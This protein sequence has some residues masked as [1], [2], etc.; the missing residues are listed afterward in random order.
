MR[1]FVKNGAAPN[2]APALASPADGITLSFFDYPA[3]TWQPITG[4]AAYT[5]QIATNPEGFGSTLYSS[6]TAATAH[7]PKAKLANGTYYWRVV[8]LDLKNREGTASAVRSFVSSYLAPPEIIEP[9]DGATPSFTPTF[10]WKALRGAEYYNIQYA[11]DSNFTEAVVTKM[12]R[13]TTYTP[14]DDLQNELSYYWH[15]RAAAGAATSDW[16][17]TRSFI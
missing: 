13:S 7:Q 4:A 6:I 10:R 12:V 11:R 2:A 9:D 17:P 5:S 1:T 3:F 14:E 15:M 8:R 16:S